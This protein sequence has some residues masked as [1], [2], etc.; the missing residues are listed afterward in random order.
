MFVL[1]VDQVNSRAH[2]DLVERAVREVSDRH[3]E[4]LVMPAERTAGDEFQAA[5]DDAG[6]VLDIVLELT[7]EGWWSVGVGVGGVR[8]PLPASTREATGDAYYAARAAV[9]RAKRAQ[10]RFALQTVAAAGE[11]ADLARDCEALIDL[12]LSLRERRTDGGWEIAD[13]LASGMSQK[14]A[15]ESLGITASAASLRIKAAGIR[16]EERSVAALRRLLERLGT[17]AA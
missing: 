1:T 2:A 8:H 14:Q 17:L 16:L 11:A 7:R 3:A 6:A 15:A 13:L 10:T 9:D 12:L 5:V 4:E